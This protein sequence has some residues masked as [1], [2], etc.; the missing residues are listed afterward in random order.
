MGN[1]GKI[2]SHESEVGVLSLEVV[3][4]AEAIFGACLAEDDWPEQNTLMKSTIASLALAS[5]VATGLGGITGCERRH[6]AETPPEG[7]TAGQELDDKTLASKVRSALDAD[8]VKYTDVKVA[9]YKGVV[10]LSGFAD[11][12][13]QKS[14]ADDI[15][16]KVAGVKKV[17]NNITLKEKNP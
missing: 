16:R 8:T 11:T 5:I 9:A 10:Q 1:T 15:S 13:E 7:R 17:E 14:R 6:A 4:K 12:S 2:Q 3:G